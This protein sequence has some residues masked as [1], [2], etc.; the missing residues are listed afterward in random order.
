ML[1]KEQNKIGLFCCIHIGIILKRL[2]LNSCKFH[3]FLLFIVYILSLIH[4]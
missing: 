3:R 2:S 1:A 4:I